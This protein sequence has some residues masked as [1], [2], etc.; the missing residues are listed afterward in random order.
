MITINISTTITT[1]II[2]AIIN[3]ITIIACS[4]TCL[5]VARFNAC[6]TREMKSP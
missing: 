3:S 6:I 1:I 4:S 2:I 5:G